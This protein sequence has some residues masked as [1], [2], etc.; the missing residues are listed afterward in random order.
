MDNP[1]DFCGL[2]RQK[3]ILEDQ[4][5]ARNLYARA[6]QKGY[7]F[8]DKHDSEYEALMGEPSRQMDELLIRILDEQDRMA[9]CGPERF[10]REDVFVWGGPTERW[11]GSMAPDT[12]VRGMEFFG[13]EN[14]VYVYG[15]LDDD[16]LELHRC[17]KRLICQVTR[18][19]RSGG[20]LESDVQCAERLSLLSRKYTN[21]IGGIADDL[22]SYLGS[23]YSVKDIEEVHA[24]L[25]RHNEALELY[26]VVYAQELDNRN[27]PRVAACI[28]AVNLWLITSIC[29]LI[30]R[31]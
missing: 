1:I 29:L 19:A 28:D 31:C 18:T 3:Q 5:A 8:A 9:A 11:G 2:F 6:A 26:G 14:A 10:R 12:S 20:Q 13:A 25:K 7:S 23:N 24:A 21:I 22:V 17:C 27:I 15:P 16:A 4:M 30:S